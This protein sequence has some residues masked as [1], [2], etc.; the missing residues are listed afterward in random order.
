MQNLIHTK[1]RL[2]KGLQQE[3]NVLSNLSIHQVEQALEYLA[4]P[5]QTYPLPEELKELQPQEWFLL[6]RMLQALM[7]ERSSKPL[8]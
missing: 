7:L 8:Q 3:K 4:E 1:G 6:E 2:P 5:V